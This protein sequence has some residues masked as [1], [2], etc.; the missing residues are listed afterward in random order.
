MA[1]NQV[2]EWN[3]ALTK[4]QQNLGA[5]VFYVAGGLYYP[6]DEALAACVN[7]NRSQQNCLIILTTYGGLADVAYKMGRCLQLAYASGEVYLFVSETCK[8]AGTLLAIGATELIMSD[9]ADLGPLDVQLGK[10]DELGEV[11]SGLTPV[12]ALMFLRDESFKLFESHFLELLSRSGYRITT[13]TAAEIASRLATGLFGPVYAQLDPLRL[14]EYHRDMAVAVEYGKRLNINGNLKASEQDHA[15]LRKLTHGYP[16]H[17]FVIDRDEARTIFNRVRPPVEAENKLAQLLRHKTLEDLEKR[18]SNG[19]HVPTV[20]YLSTIEQ[21]QG[22]GTTTGP[23]GD[24]S[25]ITPDLEQTESS[26]GSSNPTRS[27]GAT[28]GEPD[29]IPTANN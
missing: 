16:S 17:D 27:S 11:I 25:A 9:G 7:Q 18:G 1:D 19:R 12:Q 4:V 2:L 14:G 20:L 8:S 29:E 21:E 10:P 5:D 13:K 28:A 6:A 24:P 15:Q 3:E 23:T 26:S 22:D